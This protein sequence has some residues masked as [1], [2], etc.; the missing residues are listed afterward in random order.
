LNNWILKVYKKKYTILYCQTAFKRGAKFVIVITFKFIDDADQALKN[1]STALKLHPN[2]STENCA[3]QPRLEATEQKIFTKLLQRVKDDKLTQV[4]ISKR[5][6]INVKLGEQ[7][8]IIT[9]INE[10]HFFIENDPT[11]DHFTKLT[12]KTHF[13]N[14]AYQLMDVPLEFRPKNKL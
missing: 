9:D 14:S 1:R 4:S 3:L 6:F 8:R 5:G 7:Y 10:G 11:P 12:A 13:V 2:N